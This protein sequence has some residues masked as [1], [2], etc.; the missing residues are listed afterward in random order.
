MR[1]RMNENVPA[2]QTMPAHKGI[3][4]FSPWRRFIAC[5]EVDTRMLFVTQ[6]CET[7]KLS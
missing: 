7:K 4:A 6:S 2:K 5:N 1:E 3:S